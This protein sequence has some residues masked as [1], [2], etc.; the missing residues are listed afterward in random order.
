VAS[1]GLDSSVSGQER[2]VGCSEHGK[3]HSGSIRGSE[4]D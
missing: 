2:E 4:F 1:C 3:E